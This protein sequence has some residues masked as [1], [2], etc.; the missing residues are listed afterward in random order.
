VVSEQ[1]SNALENHKRGVPF[2]ESP[3]ISACYNFVEQVL[4]NLV[5]NLHLI[6]LEMA[7]I[8]AIISQ[9]EEIEQNVNEV[10]WLF[11]DLLIGQWIGP[12]ITQ[13]PLRVG[14]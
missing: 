2:K 11:V 4:I 5:K 7:Q 1:V 12:A 10:E 6:P 13:M 9:S 3:L 8:L 14:L